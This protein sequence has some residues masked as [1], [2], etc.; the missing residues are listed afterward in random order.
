MR[1]VCALRS[2]QLHQAPHHSPQGHRHNLCAHTYMHIHTEQLSLVV[3]V[4]VVGWTQSCEQCTMVLPFVLLPCANMRMIEPFVHQSSRCL[5]GGAV[6]GVLL[7]LTL[8]APLLPS[9]HCLPP[10]P[11]RAASTCRGMLPSPVSCRVAR[12]STLPPAAPLPPAAR[13]WWPVGIHT[14][15]Q[16]STAQHSTDVVMGCEVV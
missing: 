16:H 5:A 15:T 4:G 13:G 8:S 12:S 7:Y 1:A 9:I 14:H 6:I 10:L 2:P 11:P 3:V